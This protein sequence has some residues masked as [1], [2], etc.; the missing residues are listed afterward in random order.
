MPG[1]SRQKPR[2]RIRQN[3]MN[4]TPT[5]KIAM[6]ITSG[7]PNPNQAVPVDDAVEAVVAEV[8]S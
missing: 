6:P 4:N 3:S 7:G 1:R 5:T 8:R 2:C